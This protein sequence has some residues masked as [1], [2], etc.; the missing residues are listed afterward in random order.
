MTGHSADASFILKGVISYRENVAAKLGGNFD[1]F[2]GQLSNGEMIAIKLYRENNMLNDFQG[3]KF[4]EV[5][6]NFFLCV[7]RVWIYEL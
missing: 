6:N 7:A 4:V 2:R 3:V 1:I 5:C